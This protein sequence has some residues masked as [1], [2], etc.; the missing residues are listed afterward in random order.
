MTACHASTAARAMSPPW[1]PTGET[2][3]KMTSLHAL[4]EA[5]Q[6]VDQADDQAQWLDFRATI[7]SLSLQ[8]ADIQMK[9]FFD[10]S[11][12]CSTNSTKG[13]WILL[14]TQGPVPAP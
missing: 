9:A 4:V 13:V 5:A 2:Q 10:M 7:R 11:I 1:S 3:P 8:G 6:L 12:S 14:R